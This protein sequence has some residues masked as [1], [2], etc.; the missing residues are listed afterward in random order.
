MTSFF[1]FFFLFF[2]HSFSYL[3]KSPTSCLGGPCWKSPFSC[4]C[5]SWKPVPDHHLAKRWQSNWGNKYSGRFYSSLLFY[6]FIPTQSKHSIQRYLSI[7]HSVE[8]KFTANQRSSLHSDC[9]F[10]CGQNLL[11]KPQPV[12][13]HG[14]L[15]I[16]V[17]IRP[18]YNTVVF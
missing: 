9:M 2:C 13:L 17:K 7:V 18:S 4:M 8:N 14:Q 11:D 5:C 12:V 15:T 16:C 6:I 3:L 10:K 1:L